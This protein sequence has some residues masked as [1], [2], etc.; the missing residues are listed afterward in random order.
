MTFTVMILL[1]DVIPSK[2]LTGVNLTQ[3]ALYDH[4]GSFG[5]M[6]VAVAIFFFAF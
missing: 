3:A 6:F 5:P 4:F 2:D 1:A